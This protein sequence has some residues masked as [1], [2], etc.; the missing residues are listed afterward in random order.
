MSRESAETI[1]QSSTLE[2]ERYQYIQLPGSEYIR[3]LTLFPGVKDT[4]PR[5]HISAVPLHRVE[6]T[7]EAL[8]YCWGDPSFAVKFESRIRVK[9]WRFRGAE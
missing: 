9:L 4:V 6:H 2:L 8:S 1:P 3:I 7:Y 5:C